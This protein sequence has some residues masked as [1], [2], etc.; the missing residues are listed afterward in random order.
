[1]VGWGVGCGDPLG[2]MEAAGCCI[3]DEEREVCGDV[4]E[5][6]VE[7]LKEEIRRS[8]WDTEED[9]LLVEKDDG[10]RLIYP[11]NWDGPMR[12]STDCLAGLIR[13]ENAT[14]GIYKRYYTS[15]KV[16]YEVNYVDGKREGKWVRYYKSGKV[17]EEGNYKDGKLNGKWIYYDEE[18]TITDEDI[19][20]N[21]VCVQMC[22]GNE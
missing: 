3:T 1:M 6:Y 12:V 7:I 4:A 21:G 22:E 5:D 18:G 2:W 19:Y 15:G 13:L 17:F 14:E 20:E 16:K 11:L 10:T 8:G 9:A